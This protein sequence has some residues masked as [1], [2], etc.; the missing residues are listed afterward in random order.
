MKKNG[1]VFSFVLLMVFSCSAP[2]TKDN[3]ATTSA[4]SLAASED[5]AL[6]N[7]NDSDHGAPGINDTWKEELTPEEKKFFQLL[8]ENSAALFAQ[9]SIP[10]YTGSQGNYADVSWISDDW[11]GI[12]ELIQLLNPNSAF[13][14][15]E[16]KVNSWQ[17]ENECEMENFPDGIYTERPTSLEQLINQAKQ[18]TPNP[19][20]ENSITKIVDWA[21]QNGNNDWVVYYFKWTSQTEDTLMIK[22]YT[23]NLNG[24]LKIFAVSNFI[25]GG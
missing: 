25:C 7:F 20:L 15:N 2:Q 19:K 23:L 18:P 24:E 13:A 6:E 9:D 10:F 5:E 21:N 17:F 14:K 4:D 22:V 12:D 16:L 8:R 3:E 11:L 1:I